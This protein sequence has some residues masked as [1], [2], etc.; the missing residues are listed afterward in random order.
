MRTLIASL[1][2][3]MMSVAC[4][5]QENNPKESEEMKPKMEKSDQEWK[6]K[7]S[8]DEYYIL[9]EAGTERPFT[10]K[11]N[12]HFEEGNYRCAACDAVLFDSDSKFES[13][14]GWPSFDNVADNDAIIE[15]EDR[16]F[17][18]VR[19]EVICANCGGHLGHLFDDGPTES[20]MR[21]CINSVALDFEAKKEGEEKSEEVDKDESEASN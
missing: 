15:R 12:L 8:P 10:G 4:A 21:Y 2:L 14:C 19:T 1:S 6:E 7:L 20:G 9:R 18:M 5:G 13:H 11:Y 17:G 16:S 3:V